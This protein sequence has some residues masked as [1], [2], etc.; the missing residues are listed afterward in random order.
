MSLVKFNPTRELLSMERELNKLFNSLS[1]R[2][3]NESKDNEEFENAVWS[4]LTDVVENDHEYLLKMDLPGINKDDVKISVVD[5]KLSISG[6]RKTIDE[7]KDAKFHR[8]ERTYGKFYR[9]YSLPDE[10]D[11]EKIEASFREGELTITIP[12][13]EEKKPK[14]ISIKLS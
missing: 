2:M 7:K 6:E 14:E 3:W 5:R 10:A 11:F 9:T 13:A 12:K 4:P 8:I 1:G